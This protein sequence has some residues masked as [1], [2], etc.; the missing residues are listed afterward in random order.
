MAI[1]RGLQ[2]SSSPIVLASATPSLETFYNSK[3]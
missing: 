1:Y 2:V 3:K